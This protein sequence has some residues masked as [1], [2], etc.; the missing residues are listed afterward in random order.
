MS[1]KL[2]RL[3]VDEGCDYVWRRV[4]EER[5]RGKEPEQSIENINIK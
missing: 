4:I 1:D 5:N 2:N 3:V